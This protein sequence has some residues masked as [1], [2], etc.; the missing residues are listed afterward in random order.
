MSKTSGIFFLKPPRNAQ[1][2]G[3]N[4]SKA[5][6]SQSLKRRWP[7]EQLRQAQLQKQQQRTL[8]T[9]LAVPKLLNPKMMA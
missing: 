8:M 3:S 4:Q 7:T 2:F 6:Q 1:T 5:K 9:C